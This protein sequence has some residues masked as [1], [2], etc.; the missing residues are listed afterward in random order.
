MKRLSLHRMAAFAAVLVLTACAPAPTSAP[1]T[2]VPKPIELPKPTGVSQPS[3]V[4]PTAVPA[5]LTPAVLPT[6]ASALTAEDLLAA[7]LSPA[8]VQKLIP[9]P[10]QWWPEFPQF[11]VGFSA[12]TTGKK[13][14]GEQFFVLQNYR[15][16][17]PLAQGRVE[18]G[19]TLYVDD[20]SAADSFTALPDTNDKGGV[21]MDG[22]AIGDESR[23]FTRCE[24]PCGPS[25]TKT[26]YETT[27][28]F[29]VGAII[30]RIS[31][32][33]QLGYGTAEALAKYAE[34]VVEKSRALLSGHL[35]A[36]PLPGQYGSQLP[37]ASAD[38]GPILGSSVNP[39][40][41]WALIDTSGKPEK[42]RDQLRSLGATEL[43]FRRFALPADRDQVVEVT[44]FPFSDDK[45]AATWIQTFLHNARSSAGTL[46]AGNTGKL[47][48]FEKT[49]DG[50]YEL[51][52]AAGS[53]VGDV[54]CYAPYASTS[55][56][57][58]APVRRLAERWYAALSAP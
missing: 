5:T 35:K 41:S 37:A 9:D 25:A 38:V 19:L 47:S 34:P 53:F 49:P 29:R 52:F 20:K 23:Y 40:E 11:N 48:A 45:A 55:S 10:N 6:P 7:A 17:S 21:P 43:G 50:D 54:F 33:Y 14:P 8:D 56:A 1:P 18:S 31:I 26:P 22:P 24:K 39:V 32:F 28:R 51:Q 13:V 57:C 15:Q 42:V 27:L 2:A 58:E 16:V 12:S 46:D 30:G 44:L 36:T 4:A 3:P